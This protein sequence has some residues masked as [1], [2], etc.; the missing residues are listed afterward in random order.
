VNAG[1]SNNVEFPKNLFDDQ[2]NT[3]SKKSPKNTG[4]TSN[5]NN[6]NSEVEWNE[7]VY[8]EFIEYLT[9]QM[10]S[11]SH[12][13]ILSHD[14]GEHHQLGSHQQHESTVLNRNQRSDN[15]SSS[16]SLNL[17]QF[18]VLLCCVSL[19]V[20]GFFYLFFVLVDFIVLLKTK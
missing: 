20:S 8:Q 6:K 12:W 13:A 2:N 14:S 9:I 7:L 19:Q 1:Y 11:Y 4:T 15:N 5:D 16:E 17:V 18:F 10:D 3:D